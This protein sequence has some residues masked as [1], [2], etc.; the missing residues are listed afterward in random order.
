MWINFKN[1][2]K[3]VNKQN[4]LKHHFG[5]IRVQRCG[6]FSRRCGP[7]PQRCGSG[8]HRWG[9]EPQRCGSGRQIWGSEPEV[10]GPEP[11]RW[12]YQPQNFLI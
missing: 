6:Y 11:H 5:V 4:S 8:P 2:C 3:A 10:C 9:W 7:E 12:G 1:T